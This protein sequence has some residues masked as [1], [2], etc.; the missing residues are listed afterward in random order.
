M[1]DN[2][3]D[4]FERA[5]ER[6]AVATERHG[7]AMDLLGARQS[8]GVRHSRRVLFAVVV[9]GFVLVVG[10]IAQQASQS[11]AIDV[12]RALAV[13]VRSARD[14]ARGAREDARAAA[15]EAAE[16]REEIQTSQLRVEP[17]PSSAAG[18]GTRPGR[19]IL[20]IPARPATS[21]AP[22][23]PAASIPIVIGSTTG[24]GP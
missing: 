20:R 8:E 17:P 15:Q 18:A 21:T 19:A 1:N 4:R 22:A 3:G 14:E 9:M 7:E 13:E 12:L 23:A 11:D 5:L 6:V 16:A 2:G 24:G 10:S